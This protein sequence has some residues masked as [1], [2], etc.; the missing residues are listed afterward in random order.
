MTHF[1]KQK[2]LIRSVLMSA[3]EGVP[4]EKFRHDY[5]EIV[6]E[7]LSL[8]GYK[9]V[10]E[11]CNALTDTI[12]IQ[13]T[14]NSTLL[15]AVS[16]SSTKHVE[17]LISKQKKRRPRT[18]TNG[19]RGPRNCISLNPR[20]KTSPTPHF[21]HQQQ[22]GTHNTTSQRNPIDSKRSYEL[23]NRTMPK[24]RTSTSNQRL[25]VW[26]RLGPAPS[27]SPHPQPPYPQRV[28]T[29]SPVEPPPPLCSPPPPPHSSKSWIVP[30]NSPT[31]R[32]EYSHARTYPISDL[33]VY[34]KPGELIYVIGYF[35]GSRKMEDKVQESG[36]V[37][38]SNTLQF[39]IYKSPTPFLNDSI[40]CTFCYPNWAINTYS[41]PNEIKEGVWVKVY[42]NYENSSKIR[43]AVNYLQVF[44]DTNHEHTHAA[45]VET[46]LSGLSINNNNSSQNIDDGLS[47]ASDTS[48]Y[49]DSENDTT[50]EDGARDQ[51]YF[52]PNVSAREEFPHS[53]AVSL[54]EVPDTFSSRV[55]SISRL[56]H[57]YLVLED[58]NGVL[59]TLTE[60]LTELYQSVKPDN[61]LIPGECKDLLCSAFNVT[62]SKWHRARFLNSYPKASSTYAVS[63]I[64]LGEDTQIPV[65][66]I[67]P[68]HPEYLKLT[69]QAF[70]CTL[71]LHPHMTSDPQLISL[72]RKLVSDVSLKVHVSKKME[73]KLQVDLTT[74]DGKNIVS[75][76]MS[77]FTDNNTT[78]RNISLKL[79][80]FNFN[81]NSH[82]Q[83][84]PPT[85]LYIPPVTT[86]TSNSSTTPQSNH[87]NQM[88]LNGRQLVAPNYYPNPGNTFHST[89]NLPPTVT[90]PIPG[91]LPSNTSIR[92]QN[93]IALSNPRLTLNLGAISNNNLSN[94]IRPPPV[95]LPVAQSPIISPFQPMPQ[96]FMMMSYNNSYHPESNSPAAI[97]PDL[98]NLVRYETLPIASHFEAVVTAI[99]S[100][101]RF[102]VQNCANQSE[103]CKL[104]AILQLYGNVNKK[105]STS[106]TSVVEL[107]LAYTS[108]KQWAR[109]RVLS[110]SY[111]RSEARVLL[112]DYGTEEYVHM[113]NLLKLSHNHFQ[114]PFQAILVKLDK[115]VPL[116]SGWPDACI[117]R[118][119]DLALNKVMHAYPKLPF[120]SI[121]LTDVTSR[122]HIDIHT[123]LISEG[124]AASSTL[125]H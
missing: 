46:S 39:R 114:L 121:L 110:M 59:E 88:V 96:R 91:P 13:R 120:P 15:F 118:F 22:R 122:P 103:L 49:T 17:A 31:W 100:P 82:N 6:M 77:A 84:T 69:A 27:A 5:E 117:S 16:H 109:V 80:H 43:I 9:N 40:L 111:H 58:V 44:E 48:V 107:C 37:L 95:R 66:Y 123:M 54:R 76:I 19:Y 75:E 94:G 102:Y 33:S 71:K 125:K 1:E 20:S 18:G 112:L 64:D 67:R 61:V 87:S 26:G 10:E 53:S 92:H 79:N 113:N 74:P 36:R 56:S 3:S 106:P 89:L 29:I 104:T 34:G 52:S 23:P 35:M 50:E 32:H 62:T 85:K 28:V 55:K 124:F 73:N 116:A 68:I 21:L 108:S 14:S 51:R 7:R 115:V 105:T 93:Y 42:G 78:S 99:F 63:F 86:P 41:S 70:P 30:P 12:R 60:S 90:A 83:L 38:K 65:G 45:G 25:S 98:Q 24:P 8:Y 11:L 47:S 101:D 81:V 72:F 57:F 2:A 4:I 119:K 97:S